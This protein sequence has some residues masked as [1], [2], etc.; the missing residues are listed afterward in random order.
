MYHETKCDQCGDCF[1]TCQ[2]IEADKDQAVIWINQLRNGDHAEVLDKCI[3]CYACNEYCPNDANPFDL[4]AEL[5]EKYHTPITE[6][7]VSQMEQRYVF[8]G[9]LK[10][11]PEA[12]RIMSLCVFSRTDAHL[13][14][15]EL[16]DLPTVAG[17]PFFCWVMFSHMAGE[18]VQ[19]KHARELVDRLAQTKAKEV[20]CFHDDCYSILAKLAPDYGIDVPFRPIHLSEYLVEYLTANKSRLKPL[21]I[22]IA[23]SRPCASRFTPEKEHFIDELFELVGVKRV[24]REYDR[25]NAMCCGST[26]MMLTGADPKPDQE[27]NFIDAKNAG[28]KA[29]VCLCPICM[30]SFSMISQEQKLPILFIGDLARMALGEIEVP[31]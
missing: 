5:Q 17:K 7:T 6:D 29:M 16:Y 23:Y 14:Q 26:K 1:V 28:A 9:E 10:D 18:S 20:V 2:W 15:G 11:I 3:T 30:H 24:E 8:S 27:K 12:D 22:E 13:I 25:L 19:K 21:N 31:V 4:V